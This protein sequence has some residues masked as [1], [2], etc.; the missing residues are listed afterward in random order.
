MRL[1]FLLDSEKKNKRGWSRKQDTSLDYIY[2]SIYV[3][4]KDYSIASAAA[5]CPSQGTFIF[6]FSLSIASHDT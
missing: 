6:F 5:Y 1:Y 3:F 4:W 2:I